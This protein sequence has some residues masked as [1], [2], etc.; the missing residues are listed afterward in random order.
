MNVTQELKKKKNPEA[1]WEQFLEFQI[2]SL[3]KTRMKGRSTPCTLSL[4][5]GK[6]PVYVREFLAQSLEG[7]EDCVQT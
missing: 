7:Q 3:S 6:Y 5:L 1:L 2:L 4:L